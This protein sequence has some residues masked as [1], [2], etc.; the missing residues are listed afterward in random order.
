MSNNKQLTPI[1]KANNI[2]IIDEKT[3][4]DRIYTIRGIQVMLDFELAKIYGYTTKRFNEQ[5]KNNIDRFDDDFMFQLTR[6]EF[7]F[8]LRSK[9]STSSLAKHTST[10]TKDI[11]SNWGGSRYLPYAFTEQGIYMLTSV[12]RGQLAIKQS[13]QLIRAFKAMKD[14]LINTNQLILSYDNQINSQDFIL[15]QNKTYKIEE[16]IN[17]VEKDM[18]RKNDLSDIITLD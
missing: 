10:I 18:V 17:F 12:L 6:E 15:L 7:D 4:K 1:N 3:L 9:I 13:K 5:V 2:A 14:Y 16:R 11:S 8:I